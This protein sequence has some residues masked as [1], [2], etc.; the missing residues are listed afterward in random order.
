MRSISS[1]NTR[2]LPKTRCFIPISRICFQ[3]VA[4]RRL[5]R[6]EHDGVDVGI[7]DDAELTVEIGIAGHVLLFQHHRMPQPAGGILE[8]D[9]AETA[10]AFV[11]SQQRHAVESQF[12]EDAPR[13]RVACTRSSWM[14]VRDQGMMVSGMV[15]SVAAELT[16]GSSALSETRSAICVESPLMD[17]SMAQT[18]SS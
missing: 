11:D 15:G 6:P 2:K 4:G 14:V 8:L 12:G 17:P 7:L 16:M 9:H 10:V 3:D 18:F 5:S 1:P 13:Q